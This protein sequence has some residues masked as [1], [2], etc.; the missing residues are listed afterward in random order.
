MPT[1]YRLFENSGKLSGTG[2]EHFWLYLDELAKLA[3][4]PQTNPPT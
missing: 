1:D 4:Q 2:Y 3:L